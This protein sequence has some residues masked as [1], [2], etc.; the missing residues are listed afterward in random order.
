MPHFAGNACP[1]LIILLNWSICAGL[2]LGRHWRLRTPGIGCG[3]DRGA[4]ISNAAPTWR[5]LKALILVLEMMHCLHFWLSRCCAGLYHRVHKYGGH[6]LTS[7]CAPLAPVAMSACAVTPGG[8]LHAKQVVHAVIPRFMRDI[9]LLRP[10]YD[11]VLHACSEHK[12]AH[13]MGRPLC[14]F[15]M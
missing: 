11:A 12:Y 9:H 8:G 2:S 10:T 15:V 7:A 3:R 1:V 13:A 5:R 14:V 4:R 6:S